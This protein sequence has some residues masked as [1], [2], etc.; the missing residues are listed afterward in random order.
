[1]DQ[2]RSPIRGKVQNT[3]VGGPGTIP[4]SIS[5][6]TKPI[7]DAFIESQID[8]QVRERERQ[9]PAEIDNEPVPKA[10]SIT[11]LSE[12]E[13]QM[14]DGFFVSYHDND[15]KIGKEI[16]DAMKEKG[17]LIY[18]QE[19]IYAGDCQINRREELFQKSRSVIAVIS[20]DYVRDEGYH[21]LEAISGVNPSPCE[22]IEVM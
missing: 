6:L 4:S 9:L 22:L 10:A 5:P 14:K 18:S 11:E 7:L 12:R 13:Q 2:I 16:V 19:D 8:N 3:V 20:P 1:M 21:Q 17:V 15:E